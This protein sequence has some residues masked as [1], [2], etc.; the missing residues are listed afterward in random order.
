V[1]GGN[2]SKLTSILSTFRRGITQFSGNISEEKKILK[3][4][5][6][7]EYE[8]LYG[9][10]KAQ[11]FESIVEAK[12]LF[13]LQQ[14]EENKSLTVLQGE[15]P[16]SERLIWLVRDFILATSDF[17]LNE[18]ISWQS[19][20]SKLTGGVIPRKGQILLKLMKELFKKYQLA[21]IQPNVDYII[22]N[23]PGPIDSY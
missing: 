18:K 10:T 8:S 22:S 13:K 1:S 6:I 9:L 23:N 5:G 17:E 14:I 19:S 2:P 11:D 3:E 12:R 4:I 7:K 21:I 15:P 16:A 20:V